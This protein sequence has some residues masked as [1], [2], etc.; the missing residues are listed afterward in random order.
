M[1][2]IQICPMCQK[3]MIDYIEE[4]KINSNDKNMSIYSRIFLC[5]CGFEKVIEED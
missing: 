2:S 5:E 4:K 1:R 3:K